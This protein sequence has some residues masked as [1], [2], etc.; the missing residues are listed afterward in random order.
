MSPD[1]LGVDSLV[2][3]DIRSW[4][5][6]ELGLDIPVL[7]IFNAAS[8]RELLEFSF[9]ILPKS[10]GPN[11]LPEVSRE[12][13][14]AYPGSNG[15]AERATGPVKEDEIDVTGATNTVDVINEDWAEHE[16]TF[17]IDYPSNGET[18]S[19]SSSASI[20]TADLNSE[21]YGDSSS[22][23]VQ[24]DDN[25]PLGRKIQ[26]SLPMSMAQAG[27]WFL[28]N[29]VQHKTAFNVTPVFELRGRFSI[30]RFTKAVRK[31]SQHHEALRT[32][33]FVDSAQRPMQGVWDTPKLHLEHNN[34]NHE[35]EAQVAANEM[36]TYT[37]DLAEGDVIRIKVL[38][39]GLDRH[40]IIFGFHH[41]IMDGIS[42]EI[43]S[44]DLETAYNGTALSPVVQ[45]PDFAM[46][47]LQYLEHGEYQVEPRYWK[48]QFPEVPAPIP[49]LPFSLRSDRPM[50]VGFSSHMAQLSLSTA[51][52]KDIER[53]CRKFRVTPFHF[54]LATWQIFLL[55][56]LD[57]DK[58]CVG[59]GDGNRTHPDVMQ[60]VGL[61]LNTLPLQFE[62]QPAQTFG[63]VVKHTKVVSQNA[64]ANARIP[65]DAI[66]DELKVHRSAS[67]NPLFQ[68]FF[69]F[70][71]NLEVSR[72]FCG[73]TAQASLISPGDTSY[74]L[75][76]DVS[77]SNNGDTSVCLLV[78][79]DLYGF[80]HAELLLRG[81][82]RLLLEFC[83]NPA[84]QVSW[85]KLYAADDIEQGMKLGKGKPSIVPETYLWP[86][87][88]L[89]FIRTRIERNLASDCNS[90]PRHY[91]V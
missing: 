44:S 64:F 66:L 51:L 47:Q 61:F 54:H 60:T 52:A 87:I 11:S 20:M 83:R 73:C 18:E 81:Y 43:F 23:S 10:T 26:R 76:L 1:E 85:P 2:A 53:C 57:L 70:R 30:D 19:V 24:S 71:Q 77:T 78:Q 86:T 82:Q 29:F 75:Q 91:G 88:Y 55:R 56:H 22:S 35:I 62:N 3:V 90:P 5:L 31:V 4:F 12:A 69:N 72:S 89:T 48:R 41:I 21:K 27:F 17:N 63:Q 67:Y 40:W 58:I 14:Q 7:K 15:R 50:V 36:G 38:S 46:Q 59:L 74:D 39:L 80:D 49:L 32:F 9:A 33:F 6:K 25:L 8:I 45:Y 13:E 34:I 68:T 28:T 84:R 79:K 42:F 37:F 16:K 65:F